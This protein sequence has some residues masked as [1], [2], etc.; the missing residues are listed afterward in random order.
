MFSVRL[1]C[2]AVAAGLAVSPAFAEDPVIS[3]VVVM[4]VKAGT[5]ARFEDGLKKHN[6]F[7]AKKGD[8][9]SH[10]TYVVTSGPNTGDYL[11]VAG[12]RNWKDFDAEAAWQKED[13]ADSALN[14][15]AYV[16]SAVPSYY[17]LRTDLSRMPPG[18]TPMALYSLVFLRL[19]IGKV[20]DFEQALKQSKEAAD[21]AKWPR[22]SLVFSL[23]NGG[24]GPTWVISQ[25]REKFAD[26]NPPEGKSFAD[27]LEEQLGKDAAR[28]RQ[29]LSDSSV[30]SVFTQMLE[31]RADLSYVPARK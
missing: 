24:D 4:K 18:N 6:A 15:D 8:T 12:Q 26:F 5:E 29:E 14:Y 23:L 13:Q 27:M 20:D 28:L 2:L 16:E 30:A 22:Y 3:R 21:K 17:R 31:Y 19:K 25:P 9:M 10:N 1:S 11:R 7:H